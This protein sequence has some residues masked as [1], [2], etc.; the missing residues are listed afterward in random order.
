MAKFKCWYCKEELSKEDM[1]LHNVNNV[2]RKFHKS[3]LCKSKFIKKQQEVLAEEA[4]KK[5][6]YVE[7]DKLYQYVKRE[8]LKYGEG[9]QLSSYARGRLLSLRHG[10][11]VRRGVT[12]SKNGYPYHIILATFKFQKQNIVN[13]IAGKDFANENK[14]FDYVM[15][16]IS[17]NI[18]DVY[19]MYLN[20][21]KQERKMQTQQID[22][23]TNNDIKYIK[24]SE[25]NSVSSMM[26]SLW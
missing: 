8:I 24:K 4:A 25:T 5:A 20:K 17:N 2:N 16:I 6:E 1:E 11:F 21:A 22:V 10:D 13:S 12:L 19:N 15:A 26:E 7:W 3:R 14:K 23:N 9:M 18:N